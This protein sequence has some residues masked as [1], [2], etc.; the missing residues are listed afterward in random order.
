MQI[1][2]DGFIRWDYLRVTL[3]V[4]IAFIVCLVGIIFSH[5]TSSLPPHGLGERSLTT[6]S[7]E[8]GDFVAKAV[9]LFRRGV[10]RRLR[11]VSLFTRFMINK[12]SP[13]VIDR[14]YTGQL[15]ATFYSTETPD[16]TVPIYPPAFTLLIT[17]IAVAMCTLSSTVLAYSNTLSRQKM[18]EMIYVKRRNWRLMAQKEAA[19]T[20]SRLKS[21]FVAVA[22]HEVRCNAPSSCQLRFM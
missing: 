21:S 15:A 11:H 6:Y 5:I 19:E 17:I 3:S 10:T 13:K 12:P 4:L 16:F 8:Y 20:A 18:A 22:S 14:H 9:T 1:S 2:G 7:A